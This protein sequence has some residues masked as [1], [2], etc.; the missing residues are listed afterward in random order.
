MNNGNIETA[1]KQ[2]ETY[3]PHVNVCELYWDWW[4]IF[5]QKSSNQNLD[6]GNFANN[7]I[8]KKINTED[9]TYLK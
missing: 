2:I 9:V 4:L 7:V 1:L 8:W 5:R 3:W 6:T